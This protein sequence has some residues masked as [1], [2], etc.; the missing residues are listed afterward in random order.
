MNMNSDSIRALLIRAHIVLLYQKATIFRRRRWIIVCILARSSRS[1]QTLLFSSLLFF[2]RRTV[3]LA[4]AAVSVL[5]VAGV[6]VGL[7]YG[8]NGGKRFPGTSNDTGEIRMIQ[9]FRIMTLRHVV[10]AMKPTTSMVLPFWAN[11][12]EQPSPWI[13]FI[14]RESAER[15]SI[16]KEQRW[17]PH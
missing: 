2:R 11:M 14:V 7:L 4:V 8:L 13:M 3:I 1:C 9:I 5:V 12:C 10:L 6:V 17:T 15:Y 16:E